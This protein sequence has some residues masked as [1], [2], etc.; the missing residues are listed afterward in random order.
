MRRVLLAAA[1]AVFSAPP[2]ASAA[3]PKPELACR[4]AV[5]ATRGDLIKTAVRLERASKSQGKERCIA[6]RQYAQ[7]V[8]KARDVFT[9]CNVDRGLDADV[10]SMNAAM[11]DVQSAMSK[12]CADRQ[13]E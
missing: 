13:Q 11:S 4:R 12:S 5:V 7:V 10:S 3:A 9:R 8:S 1:C 2:T 6:F